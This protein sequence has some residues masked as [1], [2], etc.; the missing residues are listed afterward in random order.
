M[1]MANDT[2]RTRHLIELSL[3][4]GDHRGFLSPPSLVPRAQ[5][6]AEVPGPVHDVNLIL[7]AV[8]PSSMLCD[9]RPAARR[10]LRS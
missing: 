9:R 3:V 8:E 7:N 6:V 10:R 5:P 2:V 1:L 4:S